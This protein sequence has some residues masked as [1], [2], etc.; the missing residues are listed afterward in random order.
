MNYKKQKIIMVDDDANYSF[1]MKLL[2][3]QNGFLVDI[4]TDPLE[5]LNILLELSEEEKPDVLLLDHK[6]GQYFEGKEFTSKEFLQKFREKYPDIP[7]ALQ[8]A[9]SEEKPEDEMLENLDIQA[10]IDKGMEESRQLSTIKFLLKSAV[11]MKENKEQKQIIDTQQ[12]K[13][14]FFGS[15]ISLIVE[16]ITNKTMALGGVAIVM[17][18]NTETSLNKEEYIKFTEILKNANHE[19]SE[20]AKAVNFTSENTTIRGLEEILG[21]LMKIELAMNSAELNIKTDSTYEILN[22]D[23]KT[24][25]YILIEVIR[26]LI[27]QGNKKINI[28]CQKENEKVNI[29]IC[30]AI[31]KDNLLNKIS[32]LAVLDNNITII[33]ESDEIIIKIG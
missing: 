15:F 29:K 2:L 9:F 21:R 30:Y 14:E 32:K 24:I 1:A 3:E 26:N 25:I 22:C 19:L 6:L 7:V 28:E 8:T 13:D 12:Y 4:H 27:K 11:L 10:Y 5:A 31:E 20:L 23:S 33:K 16:E 18:D 17:E